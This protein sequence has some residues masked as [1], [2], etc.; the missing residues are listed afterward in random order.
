MISILLYTAYVYTNY[1]NNES[2]QIDKMLKKIDDMKFQIE[3]NNKKIENEINIS[4]MLNNQEKEN[5]IAIK[6]NDIKLQK[7]QNLKINK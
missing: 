3:E 6:E 5:N 1:K 2:K 4:L 7:L